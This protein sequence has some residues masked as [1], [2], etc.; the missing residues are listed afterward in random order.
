MIVYGSSPLLLEITPYCFQIAMDVLDY[1]MED[2]GPPP[3]DLHDDDEAEVVMLDESASS[4][5]VG[6]TATSSSGSSTTGE[7]IEAMASNATYHDTAGKLQ[8]NSISTDTE[9]AIKI[10][11]DDTAT[12]GEAPN[13]FVAF[14]KYIVVFL[15]E[16]TGRLSR[17]MERLKVDYL[18]PI[19]RCF[20]D[21]N[22]S[23]SSD[24]PMYVMH[25]M[26]M[27]LRDVMCPFR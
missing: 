11:P 21:A 7:P 5:V 4:D 17:H 3:P 24:S 27:D 26:F 23:Y 6:A 25:Q 19:V 18:F 15:V 2:S 1:D 20:R 16:S 14:P 9:V 22:Q 12:P 8:Q 10:G 13:G